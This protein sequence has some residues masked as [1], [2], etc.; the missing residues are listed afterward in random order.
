MAR[1]RIH[2]CVL[3]LAAA[4]SLSALST[5]PEPAGFQLNGDVERGRAVY[6]KSCAT[7]HGPAGDGRGKLAASLKVK[8]KDFTAPE[9]LARRSDWEVY[10]VVRDGGKVLGLSTAMF[11]FGKILSDQEIRDTAAFVR[12]LAP[13][14]SAWRLPEGPRDRGAALS[15]ERPPPVRG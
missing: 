5:P 11:G 2:F 9:T 10:L 6:L 15:S 13:R 14:R 8:P 3:A 1:F 4:A 7:C 12:S